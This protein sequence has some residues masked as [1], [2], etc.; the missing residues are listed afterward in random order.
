MPLTHTRVRQAVPF[1]RPCRMEERK[2]C[3]NRVT[4]SSDRPFEYLFHLDFEGSISD[5]HVAAVLDR[6]RDKSAGLTWLGSYPR[7]VQ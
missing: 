7:M 5:P 3:M 2:V 6:V 4:L 1:C